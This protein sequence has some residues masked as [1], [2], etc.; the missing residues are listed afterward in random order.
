M[1]K[2]IWLVSGFFFLKTKGNKGGEPFLGIKKTLCQEKK[3]PLGGF[4]A[5]FYWACVPGGGKFWGA[6]RPF[7]CRQFQKNPKIYLGGDPSYENFLALKG[8][9]WPWKK[10]PIKKVGKGVFKK[11]ETGFF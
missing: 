11:G 8:G 6:K 2:P 10:P 7:F 3:N 9:K 4:L 5:G 1:Q